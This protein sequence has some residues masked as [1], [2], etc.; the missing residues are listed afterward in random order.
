MYGVSRLSRHVPETDLTV[1]SVRKCNRFTK[2]Y[3]RVG[4]SDESFDQFLQFVDQ[5][6]LLPA[7]TV[8]LYI[9]G[10]DIPALLKQ[11][12]RLEPFIISRLDRTHGG[13]H[14]HPAARAGQP[15]GRRRLDRLE[16]EHHRLIDRESM[17]IPVAAS[18]APEI[19]LREAPYPTRAV[20][21]APMTRRVLDLRGR[22]PTCSPAPGLGRRCRID[23]VVVARCCLR[24]ER[25][26]DR[27]HARDPYDGAQ[28][29]IGFGRRQPSSERHL[30]A[31][32]FDV[33]SLRM[34][35]H[36]TES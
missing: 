24:V 36:W 20:A 15:A 8:D 6:D 3:P 28:H 7:N 18:S 12:I 14:R 11:P 35:D 16:S 34:W 27:A 31:A 26:H 22:R 23:L 29:A 33:D 4:D 25:V 30:A 9:A 10:A 19:S 21:A 1:L 5:K 32:R 13:P 2:K 17:P